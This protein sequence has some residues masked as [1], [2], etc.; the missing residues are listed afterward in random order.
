MNLHDI[1][2][3]EISHKKT[4]SLWFHLYENLRVVNFT[5]TDSRMV[6]VRVWG[7]Q[8][9]EKREWFFNGYGVSVWEDEET[10]GDECDDDCTTMWR[11]LMPK[12]TH[13]KTAKLCF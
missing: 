7:W 4:N 10:S 6:A 12:T 13:L 8:G 3:S 9:G 11:D 2:L 1:M 5:E